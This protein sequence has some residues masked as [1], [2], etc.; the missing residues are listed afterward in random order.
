MILVERVRRDGRVL[1][2]FP[3]PQ[4]IRHPQ[5]ASRIPVAFIPGCFRGSFGS[6]VS[7]PTTWRSS[8]RHLLGWKKGLRKPKLLADQTLQY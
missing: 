6:T 3:P 4:I 8:A 2:L 1:Q 7:D 5:G